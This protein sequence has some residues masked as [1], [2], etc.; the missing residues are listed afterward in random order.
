M[1]EPELACGPGTGR[2]GSA[3]CAA[4]G[5]RYTV[6]E[7]GLKCCQPRFFGENNSLVN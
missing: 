1:A 2:A 3:L 4:L 7:Q 5:A 6:R